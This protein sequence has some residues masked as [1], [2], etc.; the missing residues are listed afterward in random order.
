MQALRVELGSLSLVWKKV[1]PIS[2][3]PK[4]GRDLWRDGKLR[5][6]RLNLD[7]SGLSAGCVSIRRAGHSGLF[8]SDFRGTQR[9]LSKPAISRT[10]AGLNRSIRRRWRLMLG[11]EDVCT[12]ASEIFVSAVLSRCHRNWQTSRTRV[13]GSFPPAP[14]RF[15][16]IAAINACHRQ[17]RHIKPQTLKNGSA[18][19]KEKSSPVAPLLQRM[20]G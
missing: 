8:G 19:P 1:I 7:A 20:A 5:R 14:D 3:R 9:T 4:A 10:R 18:L 17:Q 11:N 16:P 2:D 15:L 12:A 6:L 13:T